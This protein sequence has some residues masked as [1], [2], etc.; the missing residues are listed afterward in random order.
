MKYKIK[1]HWKQPWQTRIEC[2]QQILTPHDWHYSVDF[3]AWPF[4]VFELQLALCNWH[5]F[6]CPVPVLLV[7]AHLLKELSQETSLFSS[8][9]WI[10]SHS[11]F[12]IVHVEGFSQGF[13]QIP[14]EVIWRCAWNTWIIFQTPHGFP[15][16]SSCIQHIP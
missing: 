13:S 15:I 1:F 10:P 8:T 12:F 16:D 9:L 2:S 14:A 3:R 4:S 7:L 5:I 11:N 6:L